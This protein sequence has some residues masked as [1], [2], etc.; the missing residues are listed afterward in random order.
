[1]AGHD[2]RDQ[3]TRH[4]GTGADEDTTELFRREMSDVRPIATDRIAPHPLR[5]R[6]NPLPLQTLQA[7][8]QVL[9]DMLSDEQWPDDLETGDELVYLKPGLQSR[10]LQRLRRGHFALNAELDLHGLNVS[11]AREAL[12]AFLR[13]CAQRDHRCVRIVHGKGRGSRHGRPVIKG[14][15][16]RWLRLRDEVVAFC[17]ARRVDGGTGAVYV[18]LKH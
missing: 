15:V 7:E 17:S 3:Q 9:V 1:M 8:Q 6:P 14:K 11:E 13:E 5:P 10:L 12:A 4:P 18:L 2:P 16:D